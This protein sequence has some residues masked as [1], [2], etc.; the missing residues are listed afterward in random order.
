VF[1]KKLEAV[2]WQDLYAIKSRHSPWYERTTANLWVGFLK[3]AREYN[4]PMNINTLRMI[5]VSMLADTIA[6]RLD[7]TI[8]HYREYRKYLKGAGKRARKRLR[9]RL[10]ETFSDTEMISWEQGLQTFSGLMYRLQRNVDST[11]VQY[12]KLQGKAAF[13]LTTVSSAILFVVVATGGILIANGTYIHLVPGA[14]YMGPWDA[15]VERILPSGIYQGFLA[16]VFLATV[17]R[18]LFRL[19]DK[20][21]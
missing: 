13:G 15:L 4:V 2:F 17:R 14:E 11:F 5:R 12:A 8:D 18:L 19:G 16:L 1:A 20:D 3:L 7:P 21:R 9:K 6:L 10:Q